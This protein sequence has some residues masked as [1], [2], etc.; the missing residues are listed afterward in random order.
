MPLSSARRVVLL[1]YN[2][3]TKTIE[4]RHYLISVRQVG[5]SRAVRRIIDGSA[6]A[7]ATGSSSLGG[8]SDTGSGGGPSAALTAAAKRVLDLGRASDISD[9]ILRHE[10]LDAYSSAG[11][12]DLSDAG[13][14]SA[15][16]GGESS[17]GGGKDEKRGRV[18][19]PGDYVGRGNKGQHARGQ[20]RAVKLLEIGPRMEL[21]LIKVEEGVGEGSVLFHEIVHKTARDAK[22]LHEAHAERRRLA[23][24]RRAEQQ[25]NVEAKRKA[26]D[27]VKGG[28]GADADDEG[29]GEDDDD[30]EDEIESAA[31][32]YDYDAEHGLPLEEA[33]PLDDAALDDVSE[34]ESDG[35]SEDDDSASEV[36]S[37]FPSGSRA[38]G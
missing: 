4:F 10:G 30:E 33:D 8:A 27:A 11:E 36:R 16:E 6:G 24:Q 1:S 12:S 20:K 28:A 7:R 35:L 19:L 17:D 2:P 32:D 38:A 37:L 3:T 21:G 22:R 31:E 14:G 34:G 13:G 5:V 9:Y 15:S 26:K 29:E 25:A 23:A 18:T